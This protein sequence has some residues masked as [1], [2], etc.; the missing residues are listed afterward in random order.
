ML[1]T[2]P[3]RSGLSLDVKQTSIS[4]SSE[5][6]ETEQRHSP[7]CSQAAHTTHTAPNARIELFDPERINERPLCPYDIPD[8]KH[9]E[10][11]PVL[12]PEP[13]CVASSGVL[14]TRPGRAVASAEHIRA[15]HEELVGVEGF[16][17]TDKVLP[18]AWCGVERCARCMG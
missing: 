11:R 6:Y 5:G 17:R 3:T 9:R 13:L 1:A 15:D 16:S 14:R 2:F 4:Q 18:P 7:S 12:I 10:V 8:T